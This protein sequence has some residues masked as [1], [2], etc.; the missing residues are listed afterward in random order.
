MDC[1]LLSLYDV[2]EDIAEY[3]VETQTGMEHTENCIKS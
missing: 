2:F 3:T 1:I